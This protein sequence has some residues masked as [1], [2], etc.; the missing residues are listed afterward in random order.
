M[1]KK[2]IGEEDKNLNFLFVVVV[3]GYFA[4]DYLTFVRRKRNSQTNC[5]VRS[6]YL[7]V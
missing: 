2:D 4:S 1:L 3:F 5:K 7:C 6:K